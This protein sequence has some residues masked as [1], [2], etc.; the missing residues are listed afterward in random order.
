MNLGIC[1]VR[2]GYWKLH[3]FDV[4]KNGRPAHVLREKPTACSTS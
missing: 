4:Y 3:G 2:V 1:K